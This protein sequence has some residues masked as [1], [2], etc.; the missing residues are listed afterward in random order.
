MQYQR[1]KAVS[2]Q[3]TP[4]NRKNAQYSDYDLNKRQTCPYL[5][6]F[7]TRITGVYECHG[8]GS[9]TGPLA[10]LV[11]RPCVSRLVLLL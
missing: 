2:E 3:Q 7:I 10:C 9:W 1:I 5:T 6:I 8:S 11:C 4:D